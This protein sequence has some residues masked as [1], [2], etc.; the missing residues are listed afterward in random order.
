MKKRSYYLGLSVVVICLLAITLTSLLLLERLKAPSVT[1]VATVAEQPVAPL[2]NNMTLANLE[3]EAPVSSKVEDGLTIHLSTEQAT[4]T[5]GQPV[6]VTVSIRNDTLSPIMIHD[7][8]YLDCCVGMAISFEQQ[9]YESYQGP[10]PVASVYVEPTP[11]PPGAQRSFSFAIWY[12]IPSF[13]A[14]YGVTHFYAFPK[15]GNYTLRATLIEILPDRVVYSAPLAIQLVAPQGN[16]A[17]VWRLLQ[18][19]QAA[20]FLQKAYTNHPEKV[21]PTFTSILAAYPESVY[22]PYLRIALAAYQATQPQSGEAAG[23]A[24]N[25]AAIT[26]ASINEE[27]YL[28]YP[29][30][31]RAMGGAAGAVQPDTIKT[32]VTVAKAWVEAWNARDIERLAQLY[33]YQTFFRQDWEAGEGN[34]S[35][36]RT[37]KRIEALFT[38]NGL[39][40][41]ELVGFT[42]GAKEITAD[43]VGRFEHGKATHAF[44]TMR[45]VLDDDG[46]WRIYSPGY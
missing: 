42:I 41:V 28:V 19:E 44:E 12:N 9:P 8:L 25:A 27:V 38:E 35:Y 16:D 43:V 4:Y 34:R 10:F 14:R 33:S 1:V 29:Q 11:L 26:L 36:Q 21:L 13:S 20:Q 18:T 22:A 31:D 6:T 2:S 39:V 46:V 24:Q 17:T 30:T 3:T 40:M 5:L 45:F 32:V 37:R 23:T 15:A 7:A